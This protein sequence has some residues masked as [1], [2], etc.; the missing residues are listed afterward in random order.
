MAS[1][2]KYYGRTAVPDGNGLVDYQRFTADYFS[3]CNVSL[4]FGDVL[5]DEIVALECQV[6]EQI[7]P[8]YGYA[9]YTYDAIAHGSRLVTGSFKINFVQSG[10]L[11]HV[12]NELWTEKKE[13]KTSLFAQEIAHLE[14][15]SK[16]DVTISNMSSAD[17]MTKHS[18]TKWENLDDYITAYENLIWNNDYADYII[19]PS[20]DRQYFNSKEAANDIKFDILINYSPGILNPGI[21]DQSV[22]LTLES[23][24]DVHIFSCSKVVDPSGQPIQEVYQFMANDWNNKID[25]YKKE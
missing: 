15:S 21:M 20:H 2:P 17:F 23:L 1:V 16:N 8:V 6:Q 3:G 18:S 12:M 22:T 9:S 24:N 4:F 13:E 14:P 5:I 19:K 7:Q 25:K 10:Y 11:M